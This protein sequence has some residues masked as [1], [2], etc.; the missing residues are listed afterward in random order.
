M[1]L[2]QFLQLVKAN[3]RIVV[4]SVLFFFGAALAVTFLQPLDYRAQSRLLVIQNSQEGT[5][6]FVASKANEYL[7]GVLVKIIGSNSFLDE[8]LATSFNIDK[9]YFDNDRQTRAKVWQETVAARSFGDLGVIEISVFQ[10][11]QYQAE[12]IAQ[13]I[14]FVLTS[15]SGVLLGTGSKVDLKVI[16]QPVVSRWPVRPNIPLNL[17][18]GPVIGLVFALFYIY[19]F[20]QPGTPVPVT[21]FIEPTPAAA[22][23]VPPV[24]APAVPP[25]APAEEMPA[26]PAAGQAA[27]TVPSPQTQPV[28]PAFAPAPT[29]QAAPPVAPAEEEFDLDEILNQ[30]S[31]NNLR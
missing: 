9:G 21:V 22:P 4:M 1:E 11:D 14:D 2:S 17:A 6:P 31:M 27:P 3:K 26:P 23:A 18:L 28:A 15:K 13:A 25:V 20:R 12:Q 7:G 19:L 29:A 5:D 30:G 16:D 8:V 24:Q 10:P